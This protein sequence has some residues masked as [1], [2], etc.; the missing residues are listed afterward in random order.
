MSFV[1]F[2][3]THPSEPQAEILPADRARRHPYE[4]NRPQWSGY[5]VIG[6]CACECHIRRRACV[7]CGGLI[8]AARAGKR[9]CSDGCRQA[10][11]RERKAL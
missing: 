8:G 11:Y 5:C 9:F 4:G 7:K 3:C 2:A 10:A 1:S 6:K